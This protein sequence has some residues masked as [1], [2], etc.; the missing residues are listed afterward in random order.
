MKR[1]THVPPLIRVT[2]SVY[3]PA[4]VD[5]AARGALAGLGFVAIARPSDAGSC[6]VQEIR[7]RHR[8]S[9]GVGHRP[10]KLSGGAAVSCR[11]GG[12][13][14]SESTLG[15][16]CRWLGCTIPPGFNF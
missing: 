15:P 16:H 12:S 6:R 7:A 14:R 3:D 13:R 8:A 5:T 11:A 10:D 2:P 1:V 4:G 9:G